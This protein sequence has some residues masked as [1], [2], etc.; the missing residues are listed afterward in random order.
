MTEYIALMNKDVNTDYGVVFPDFPGCM[1]AGTTVAEAKRMAREALAGHIEI[2]KAD[3]A[4]LPYPSTYA[5]I[6]SNPAY[7]DS[8][9]FEV[10]LP[11]NLRS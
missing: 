10:A 11:S 8:L 6:M 5:E 2:M 1:T 9:A 4:A 3:G 7:R